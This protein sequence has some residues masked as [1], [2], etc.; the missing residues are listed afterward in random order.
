MARPSEGSP[1]SA[2]RARHS[3][4]RCFMP[5]ESWPGRLFAR[6]VQ[7]DQTQQFHRAFDIGGAAPMHH[8]DRKQ[9]VLQRGLPG[10]QRWILKD[11]SD[12]RARL[13]D[14]HAAGENPS[15]GDGFRDPRSSSEACSCRSRWGPAARRIRHFQSKKWR[16]APLRTRAR[17]CH[18]PCGRARSLFQGACIKPGPAARRIFWSCP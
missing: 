15:L 18:R 5:P 12:F 11:D 3:D 8:F 14:R 2:I 13:V 4:T 1:G 10:K 17:H 7:S 9:N 6:V 16:H